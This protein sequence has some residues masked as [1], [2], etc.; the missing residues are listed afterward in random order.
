MC[1]WTTVML[2][3]LSSVENKVKNFDFGS[4]DLMSETQ[5]THLCTRTMIVLTGKYQTFKA[6]ER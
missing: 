4:C 2:M 6:D 3:R 1:V 5:V